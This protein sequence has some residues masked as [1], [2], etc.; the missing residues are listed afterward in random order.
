[1]KLICLEIL[2]CNVLNK[3]RIKKIESWDGWGEMVW[4][5]VNYNMDM[6]N[7]MMDLR[8]VLIYIYMNF[9]FYIVRIKF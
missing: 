7:M 9:F 1:M 6:V 8:C 5:E 2:W 3:D 4:L